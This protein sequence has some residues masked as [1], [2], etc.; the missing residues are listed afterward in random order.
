MIIFILAQKLSHRRQ[1]NCTRF[2]QCGKAASSKEVV[3]S[4]MTFVSGVAVLAISC[5]VLTQVQWDELITIPPGDQRITSLLFFHR[6]RRFLS[7][8]ITERVT[9]R[10]FRAGFW[11]L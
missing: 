2:H 3:Y 4:Q 10:P 9:W 5:G 11:G 8:P 7:G 6:E 1:D